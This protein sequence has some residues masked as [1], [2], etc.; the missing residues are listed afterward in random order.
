[1][2]KLTRL[3][4]DFFYRHP[5]LHDYLVGAGLAMDPTPMEPPIER[6]PFA[7]FHRAMLLDRMK[8]SQDRQK[9]TGSSFVKPP[10]P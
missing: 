8:L 7:E 10:P 1:M 3:F 5:K 2:A 9:A 4:R 6:D